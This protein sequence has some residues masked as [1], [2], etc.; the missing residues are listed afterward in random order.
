MASE[1]LADDIDDPDYAS[2]INKLIKDPQ[3]LLIVARGSEGVFN[4][5]A[6][7]IGP[8]SIEGSLEDETF[9]RYSCL[10]FYCSLPFAKLIRYP[11]T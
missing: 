4:D 10:T 3:R 2:R 6:K 1:I 5:L 11:S 9:E 7:F 8:K